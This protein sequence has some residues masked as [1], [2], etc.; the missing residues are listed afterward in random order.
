MSRRI[1]HIQN[2]VSAEL[3]RH[4]QAIEVDPTI[5][6][7]HLTV[8]IGTSGMPEKVSYSAVSESR[9]ADARLTGTI[10]IARMPPKVFG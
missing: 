7:I 2:A 4:G 1:I 8:V 10:K 5:A 9:V 6:K 3:E